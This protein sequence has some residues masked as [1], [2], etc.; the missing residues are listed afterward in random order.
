VV[1]VLFGRDVFADKEGLCGQAVGE[2]IVVLELRSVINEEEG[3]KQ[4]H[5]KNDSAI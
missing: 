1:G 2:A 3:L 5:G 4:T